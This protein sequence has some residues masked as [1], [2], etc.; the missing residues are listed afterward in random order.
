MSDGSGTELLGVTVKSL[1]LEEHLAGEREWPID[2]PL[3]WRVFVEWGTYSHELPAVTP[4]I[5]A[6]V[7]FVF[8]VPAGERPPLEFSFSLLGKFQ[9]DPPLEEAALATFCQ[10]TGATALW[11]HCTALV[12]QTLSYVGV[13][14]ITLPAFA[15][16][17][18]VPDETVKGEPVDALDER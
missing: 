16:L 4:L 14:T 12:S 13:Y 11:P 6:K 9:V 17:T 15:E 1:H 8:E 2:R 7:A 3:T 10:N 18:L 5:M